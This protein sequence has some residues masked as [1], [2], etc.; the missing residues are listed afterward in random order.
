MCMYCD[1]KHAAEQLQCT[2]AHAQ[3]LI[4]SCK[5]HQQISRRRIRSGS[6]SSKD[7]AMP[8]WQAHG[9]QHLLLEACAAAD[10]SL[11][12]MGAFIQVNSCDATGAPWIALGCLQRHH[13][14]RRTLYIPGFFCGV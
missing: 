6:R 4:P 1:A 9:A 10:S 3:Q 8:K 13:C 12:P 7:A 11:Q 5:L 2:F 14:F